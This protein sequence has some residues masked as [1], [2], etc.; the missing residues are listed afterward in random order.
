MPTTELGRVASA[1]SH[2]DGTPQDGS[3]SDPE[4]GLP[5]AGK[6]LRLKPA[7]NPPKSTIYDDIPLLRF[8]RWIARTVS[9]RARV[10][11]LAEGRKPKRKAYEDLVESYVP[12]EIILVLSK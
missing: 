9:R 12:L 8:F 11:Q 1:S 5:Q 7:R 6:E 3:G 2:H 10:R 4:K